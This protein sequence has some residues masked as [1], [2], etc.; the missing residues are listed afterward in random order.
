MI[1]RFLLCGHRLT[2]IQ[3]IASPGFNPPGKLIVKRSVNRDDRTTHGAALTDVVASGVTVMLASDSSLI[4]GESTIT[5]LN[6]GSL[7]SFT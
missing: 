2:T 3:L 6:C 1:H 5:T 7:P 4:S